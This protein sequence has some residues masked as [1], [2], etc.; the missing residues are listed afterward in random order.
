MKQPHSPWKKPLFLATVGAAIVVLLTLRTHPATATAS[1][2]PPGRAAD[3]QIGRPPLKADMQE[4]MDRKLASAQ[5]ALQYV[6][7]DRFNELESACDEMIELSRHAAWKQLASPGYVQDTTDFVNAAEFLRRMAQAN[8]ADG[9]ALGYSKLVLCCSNC[10]QH[11]RLPPMAAV[12]ASEIPIASR[13]HS[14]D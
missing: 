10:H 3:D 7:T 14:I 11:V 4:F 9:V 13:T 5:H 6:A 8:D 1:Q 12:P 2:Q